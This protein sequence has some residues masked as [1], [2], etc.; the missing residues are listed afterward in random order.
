MPVGL[1]VG[2]IST[3]RKYV[4]NI[5][6]AYQKRSVAMIQL[7][8]LF[9]EI[10]S[11][12]P[13]QT[14][15]LRSLFDTVENALRSAV[16]AGKGRSDLADDAFATAEEQLDQYTLHYHARE[17]GVLGDVHD[18]IEDAAQKDSQIMKT[19]NR[20]SSRLGLSKAHTPR[21]SSLVKVRFQILHS[22]TDRHLAPIVT[23]ELGPEVNV[24]EL[25][26]T[27]SRLPEDQ[28]VTLKQNP[29]FYLSRDLSDRPDN[30]DDE[31]VLKPLKDLKPEKDLV[32]LIL[33]DRN[34][35]IY[36]D[37]E[38]FSKTYG[39][40]WKPHDAI[41]LK[42]LQGTLEAANRI[43][44]KIN[45]EVCIWQRGGDRPDEDLTEWT[46]V[47]SQAL[48][49][50]DADWLIR[51]GTSSDEAFDI[52][53]T[54]G[55][56]RCSP[57]KEPEP[58]PVFGQGNSVSPASS[59][60]DVFT[61]LEDALSLDSGFVS[62]LPTLDSSGESSY[63]SRDDTGPS[64]DT[65][66]TSVEEV[67][68][69][70]EYSPPVEDAEFS[71]PEVSFPLDGGVQVDTAVPSP[72]SSP[73]A[74]PE[75][76]DPPIGSEPDAASS[77]FVPDRIITPKR[78][79]LLVE[80]V[81]VPPQ[82]T[83]PSPGPPTPP[84]S[85]DEATA[86]DNEPILDSTTPLS[87]NTN[88]QLQLAHPS[89]QTPP[90]PTPPP[91]AS[92]A[93][94]PDIVTPLEDAR[95][96]V[97]VV[98]LPAQPVLSPPPPL[99]PPT[100]SKLLK[101]DVA[102]SH[103]LTP[104]SKFAHQQDEAVRPPVQLV[105]DPEPQVLP[106]PMI[107]PAPTSNA[108]VPS[109]LRLE[110]ARPRIEP[111]HSP[112]PP[113][114]TPEVPSPPLCSIPATANNAPAPVM[115]V[116]VSESAR[117][118][119]E[120]VHHPVQLVPAPQPLPPP[121]ASRSI[122][123]PGRV[124]T[125]LESTPPRVEMVHRPVQLVHAP[126]SLPPPAESKPTPAPDRV[127]TVL[128]STPPRVE[129]VH[130]PVQLVPV[131]PSLPP[132]AES[133]PAP[134]RV[135]TVP[136]STRPRVET[137]HRLVQPVPAPPSLPPPAGSKPT[138]APDTVATVPESTRP[139]VETANRP[140]QLVP[141]PQSLPPPMGSKP[142]PAPDRVTAIPESTRPR[143]E[144]VHR[145]VQLVP[146]PQ[147]LPP[148][149][150]SMLTPAPGR[151]A[152]VPES[153]RRRAE[154]V[155]RPVQLVPAPQSLPPPAGSK[156][157]P[158]G[159]AS[160]PNT[161]S[162][163]KSL[164]PMGSAST[165]GYTTLTSSGTR[166]QAAAVPRPVQ[167]TQPT[168]RSSA[169]PA[170]RG[171]VPAGSVPTPNMVR[172]PLE[173][174]RPHVGVGRTSTLVPAPPESRVAPITPAG[175]ASGPDMREVSRPRIKTHPRKMVTPVGQRRSVVAPAPMVMQPP[176]PPPAQPKSLPVQPTT[177][178]APQ[179]SNPLPPR[180]MSRMSYTSSLPEAQDKPK[181]R[182]A[183]ATVP[184][185]PAAH[186]A[187]PPRVG[188]MTSVP[189]PRIPERGHRVS[190]VPTEQLRQPTVIPEQMTRPT[191][192]PSTL[193]PMHPEQST[194]GSP[195]NRSSSTP[196][197]RQD[198]VA[199]AIFS[200][201]S[202]QKR[203][204][205]VSIPG[206]WDESKAGS[207]KTA[208]ATI[209]A[210]DA[211]NAVVP[212][213]N[214]TTLLIPTPATTN[215]PSPTPPTSKA[216]DLMREPRP[217]TAPPEPST[218]QVT[219]RLPAQP[220][221]PPKQPTE[222]ATSSLPNTAPVA[223]TRRGETTVPSSYR[224]RTETP[225]VVSG[226]EISQGEPKPRSTPTTVLPRRQVGY[227]SVNV[228]PEP[229]LR[230]SGQRITSRIKTKDLINRHKPQIA[231][232]VRPPSIAQSVGTPTLSKSPIS[233]MSQPTSAKPDP[234]RIDSGIE[235][236]DYGGP[237]RAKSDRQK[238]SNVPA[239]GDNKGPADGT[240][241]SMRPTKLPT[242]LDSADGKE[243]S[244]LSL[245]H[246]ESR[247]SKTP[248]PVAGIAPPPSSPPAPNTTEIPQTDSPAS[249]PGR[250]GGAFL[251]RK[252]Q[253][254]FQITIQGTAASY[255]GNST[256]PRSS[257]PSSMTHATTAATSTQVTLVTPASSFPNVSSLGTKAQPRS[258]FRRN[259]IDPF[260]T[261]LGLAPS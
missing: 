220:V 116:A 25:L 112:N 164:A 155:H 218:P 14:D 62:D 91:H 122:P 177:R 252:P 106:L 257:T 124:A 28:R 79:H 147:S 225:G 137:V 118:R 117:P 208:T 143:V 197:V 166:S 156:L 216:K 237:L 27:F 227:G 226:A 73:H 219:V 171:P 195:P 141:T 26:W 144:M 223:T 201:S 248:Q 186:P 82:S 63:Y 126:P 24:S 184:T 74:L 196:I 33:S 146:T 210:P 185:V 234:D 109:T 86:N 251:T 128:E 34:G 80:T 23:C 51:S 131:P 254:S 183:P 175:S 207:T 211:A 212:A 178:L 148:P 243:G 1:A 255:P 242:I 30:Y 256:P 190:N 64:D 132:P 95:R 44:P 134:D 202:P 238:G 176:A 84:I 160:I 221:T 182:I 241:A 159:S 17:Q 199:A 181:V 215:G 133:K 71:G 246:Q 8:R 150:G 179:S 104:A 167:V 10:S 29:H 162:V 239:N 107:E 111:V 3:F 235:L 233:N 240:G 101:S 209:P 72:V 32:V 47:L 59:R 50:P 55:W 89:A 94:N 18:I 68:N 120:A 41:I 163:P 20:L 105:Q 153:T 154:T 19:Y 121:A 228:V 42:D 229:V 115:V 77:V 198:R 58:A 61:P 113:T 6:R 173:R 129:M 203:A 110:H 56:E 69:G 21:S 158:A 7:C 250:V 52:E 48:S 260:K 100:E 22:P 36:F 102:A 145:P 66:N 259:V 206:G 12:K 193:S 83:L 231:S 187:P 189:A 97:D 140:V 136:E 45:G 165:A 98:H 96:Q 188:E 180:D 230:S 249:T 192:R 4:K 70:E 16:E 236:W 168:L 261:K 85:N 53:V 119:V 92:D 15:A 108:V 245:P 93:P 170:R 244:N 214:A 2:D 161:R 37:Y 65:I 191:V 169:L 40:I 38:K 200:G 75:L 194:N 138:P 135:A 90:F 114:R 130:R 5:G 87:E 151:V 43:S 35:Q 232:D 88:P 39:N 127:A 31:F 258:W 49:A 13:D 213:G 172:L 60:E 123:A 54:G 222:P 81:H 9:V 205:P 57:I 204:D 217:L 224:S 67:Q 149:T 142:T 103:D 125:V 139:R 152:I 157:A 11:G 76:L 46:E 174:A 78:T 247:V 99:T 253:A